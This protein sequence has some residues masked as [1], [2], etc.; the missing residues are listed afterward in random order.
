MTSVYE[1]ASSGYFLTLTS[2]VAK[3]PSPL[4]GN[5]FFP[6]LLG[7]VAEERSAPGKII[8]YVTD[9][10]DQ[11]REAGQKWFGDNF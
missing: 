5:T 2:C 10:Q 1:E 8:V 9:F 11:K 4:S 3:T 6:F 7:V